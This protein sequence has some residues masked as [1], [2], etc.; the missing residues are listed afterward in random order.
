M[1]RNAVAFFSIMENRVDGAP[2][3]VFTGR[4]LAQP[5]F[6]D[7]VPVDFGKFTEKLVK[8][9]GQVIV[10]IIQI[11]DNRFQEAKFIAGRIA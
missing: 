7:N 1:L 3:V 11:V 4:L 2:P 5:V 8:S 10:R 9:Q 6:E